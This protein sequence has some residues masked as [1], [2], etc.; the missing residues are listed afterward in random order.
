[1]TEKEKP[2]FLLDNDLVKDKDKD[3]GPKAPVENKDVQSDKQNEYDTTAIHTEPDVAPQSGDTVTGYRKLTSDDIAWMNTIKSAEIEL[4]AVWNNV[5]QLVTNAD[6][7]E[8]A[9]A[10]THFQTGF[11]HFVKAIAKPEDAF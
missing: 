11:M 1:M 2:G 7:R 10:K 9:I 3:S 5:K 8:L 4:G 6:A